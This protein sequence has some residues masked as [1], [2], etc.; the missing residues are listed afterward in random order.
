MAFLMLGLTACQ[1]APKEVKEEN[2]ILNSVDVE[3]SG[4]SELKYATMSE[5]RETINEDLE[6]IKI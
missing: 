3:D 2:K 6:K 4:D 5:I 1:S